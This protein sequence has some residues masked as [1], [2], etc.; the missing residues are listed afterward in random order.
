[1]K[2]L[3]NDK[4]PEDRRAAVVDM[5]GKRGTAEDLAFLFERTCIPGV[6]PQ[7]IRR[8]AL[9]A[10]AEATANRKVKPKTD[11]AMVGMLI[12][13]KDDPDLQRGAIRLAGMWKIPLSVGDLAA[14][15]GDP[16]TPPAIRSASVEALAAIG[17]PFAKGAVE[18]F[19]GPKR[20]KELRMAAVAAM[21]RLD[22]A[23]AATKAAALLKEA[24]PGDD[25]AALIAAFLNLKGGPRRSPRPSK[26]PTSRSI[27]RRPRSGPS[28]PRAIPT[29]RSWT[30]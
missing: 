20:P 15:A 13:S 4:L 7:P 24:A 10:I 21:A 6:F 30:P 18:D 1:M 28:T 12:R 27:R 9:D 29:R 25:V 23:S 19:A 3:K 17:G 11:L 14:V 26:R 8:K 16:G 2:L 22:L 5:I